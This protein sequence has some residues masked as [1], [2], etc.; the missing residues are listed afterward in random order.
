MSPQQ[1]RIVRLQHW[2]IFPVLLVARV[3]WCVQSILFPLSGKASMKEGG[4]ELATLALHYAWLLSA[5]LT[6][7]TP[8]KVRT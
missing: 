2:L 1:R 5:S 6:L 3:S 4:L 7:L 8:V